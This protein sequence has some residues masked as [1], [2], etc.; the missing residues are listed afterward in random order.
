VLLYNKTGGGWV[1]F[2]TMKGSKT[3]R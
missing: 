1:N 2:K 3:R